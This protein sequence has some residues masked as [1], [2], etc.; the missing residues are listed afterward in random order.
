MSLI[1]QCLYRCVD[2]ILQ[3]KFLHRLVDPSVIGLRN[4]GIALQQLKGRLTALNPV[5]NTLVRKIL[6]LHLIW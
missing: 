3:R 5:D 6:F 2:S 4:A 1:R